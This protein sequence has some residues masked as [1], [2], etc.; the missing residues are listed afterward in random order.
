MVRAVCN[1]HAGFV[2]YISVCSPLILFP[3]FSLLPIKLFVEQENEQVDVDGGTIEEL[4]HCHAFILQLEEVL[5]G[6]NRPQIRSKATQA[7][8]VFLK[9]KM[10]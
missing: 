1:P 4:H 5:T 9:I 8:K 2:V 7:K 10:C 3:L 6:T